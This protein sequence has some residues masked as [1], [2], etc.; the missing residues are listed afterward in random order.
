MTTAAIDLPST[1]IC[2][3]CLKRKKL[4][5][6]GKNPRMK[7]GRKSYCKKC[8]AELQ[9][10]WNEGPERKPAKKAT[11]RATK[12]GAAKRAKKAAKKAAKRR[13]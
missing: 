12:K 6:F 10:E 13:S 9:R 1:K 4:E 7:L 5:E 3:R 11:K 8:S 2:T